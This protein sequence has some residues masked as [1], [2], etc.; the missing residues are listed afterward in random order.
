MPNAVITCSRCKA[1]VDKGAP[2]QPGQNDAG[3]VCE[4][5]NS[6]H[7][8]KIIAERSPTIVVDGGQ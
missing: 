3:F 8:A 1:K 6:A 7:N 2:A 5:C 4:D